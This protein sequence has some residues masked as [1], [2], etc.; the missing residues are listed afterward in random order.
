MRALLCQEYGGPECLVLS[1][2]QE[3]PL[4]GDEEIR[5]AVHAAGMNFSDNLIIQNRYQEKP[6]LPFSPGFEAAGVVDAVGK[7]VSDFKPGD[8]V[9]SQTSHGAFAE[10]V[11]ADRKH[12][13]PLPDSMDFE[14]AAAFPIAYGSA[15]GALRLMGALQTGE[16]LVVHGATGGVGLAAIEVGK[17]IGAKVIATASGEEKLALA[18]ATGADAVID[19]KHED[20]KERIRQ[21][22]DGKGAD[23]IFDPVGG[24]TFDASLRSIAWNGRI[25][26]IGFAGGRVQ[27]IPANHL[28]VKNVSCLG[29]Y[30][31]SFLQHAPDQVATAFSKLFDWH[32][33]GKLT[34]HISARFPLEQAIEG[35]QMLQER[36][37]TGKIV[38]TIQTEIQGKPKP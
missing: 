34:P 26:I 35:F 28:L 32:K 3:L 16:N 33:E 6:P 18:L 21:L 38:L 9:L 22:T 23:V 1:G 10:F 20:I 25:I 37:V 36:R 27:Q 4:P 5:I 19:Y 29:F 31:G 12:V 15:Y 11:L 30:W 8:R 14:T 24:D 17:A 2:D 7:N 13:F